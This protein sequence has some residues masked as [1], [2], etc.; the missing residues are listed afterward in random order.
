MADRTLLVEGWRFIP[1]SYA[2]V[3][4]C[5]CLELL[6]VPGLALLHRDAPYYQDHWRPVAGLFPQQ[7]EDVLRSI[8]APGDDESADAELRIAFPP[9]WAPPKPR[10]TCVF[11]T[12]EYRCVPEVYHVPGRAL[13]AVLAESGVVVVTPSHWSREGFLR[14]GV[15]SGRVVVVPLGV[16]PAVFRP[17]ADAERAELRARLGWDGFIFLAVGAMTGNKGLALLLRAFAAVAG[18]H[19]HARLVL[20]GL[21]AL[22]PSW[23][24]LSEQA[25]VLTAEERQRVQ[26]RLTYLGKTFGT[27]DM[28]R[29]Y[30]AADAFV[31]PYHAEGFNLPVLEAAACG[32]LVICTRGGPTDDFTRPEFAL[33]ID[34]TLDAVQLTPRTAGQCLMPSAEHLLHQVM[35]AVERPELAARARLEGPAFVA[36]GFTWKQVVAQLLRVLFPE[37]SF[38]VLTSPPAGSPCRQ[39]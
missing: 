8:P 15:E 27:A 23:S 11:A 26:E 24:F 2:M 20:K 35:T 7:D 33:H 21:E 4:Q 38:Q 39:G 19:P 18:K 3:N 10:R 34:S 5:Q 14:A 29:L 17:L 36:R 31:S 32:T 13:P 25:A 22:Y 12:T 16:D 28:A 1:H 6:R 30:Q 37:G 9:R